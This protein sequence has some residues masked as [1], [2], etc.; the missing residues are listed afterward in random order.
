MNYKDL[1]YSAL[2]TC[3]LYMYLLPA[4]ITC[5]TIPA[6]RLFQSIRQFGSWSGKLDTIVLSLCIFK[7]G[8]NVE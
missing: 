5:T 2:E 3:Y 1:Y 8:S 4:H 6:I 7:A